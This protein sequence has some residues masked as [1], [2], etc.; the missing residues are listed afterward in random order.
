MFISGNSLWTVK[1]P[2]WIAN[3]FRVFILRRREERR[4]GSKKL[5]ENRCC[6]HR[7]AKQAKQSCSNV[8]SYSLLPPLPS[9]LLFLPANSPIHL[10]RG[11]KVPLSDKASQKSSWQQQRCF[12]DHRN[13]SF[14][15]LVW[16]FQGWMGVSS[17]GGFTK[18]SRSFTNCR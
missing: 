9:P 2:S 16:A 7:S 1:M 8:L 15:R 6:F 18:Q 10:Y 12:R 11:A 17:N 13:K 14:Y 3:H 5:L 4:R